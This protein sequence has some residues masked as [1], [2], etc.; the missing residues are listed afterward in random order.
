MTDIDHVDTGVSDT[1]DRRLSGLLAAVA[2]DTGAMPSADQVIGRLRGGTRPD[3]T[4]RRLSLVAVAVGLLLAAI[5]GAAFLAGGRPTRPPALPAA[6]PGNGWIAFANIGLGSG[7]ARTSLGLL[8]LGGRQFRVGDGTTAVG[9][10]AFSPDG[11]QLAYRSR[12]QVI[13][14][15]IETAGA[16]GRPRQIAVPGVECQVWTSSGDGIAVADGSGVL[17]RHLDGSSA[18]IDQPC[19]PGGA[20][21]FG[22]SRPVAFS[23]EGDDVALACSRGVLIVPIDAPDHPRILSNDPSSSVTWSPDGSRVAFDQPDDSIWVA[24][25]DGADPAV[26]ISDTGNMPIWS[27]DGSLIAFADAYRVRIASPD[28]TNRRAIGVE[29]ISRFGGWSPDGRQILEIRNPSGLADAWDLVAVD[30]ATDR[31]RTLLHAV[32][33]GSS[34]I[35]TGLQDVSWEPVWRD[36]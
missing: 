30:V 25:A 27:P 7:G 6:L 2:A 36:R 8:D 22:W 3:Q 20:N 9:C 1:F 10:P 18:R 26:R 29:D 21:T 35:F 5:T 11:H 34:A 19:M 23:P 12:D 17:V 24:A 33:T 4:L 15:A 31:E 28:G 16:V 32:P 13:I 14:Q